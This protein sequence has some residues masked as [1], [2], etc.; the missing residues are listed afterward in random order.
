M[1]VSPLGSGAADGATLLQYFF[2]PNAFFLAAHSLIDSSRDN[3]IIFT[4]GGIEKQFSLLSHKID[5]NL[6]VYYS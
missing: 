1:G 4:I 3:F 2:F 5:R 6:N